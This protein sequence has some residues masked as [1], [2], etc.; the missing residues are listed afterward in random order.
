MEHPSI[1]FCIFLFGCVTSIEGFTIGV[2]QE[3]DNPFA[4]NLNS[5]SRILDSGR[6]GLQLLNQLSILT[7]ERSNQ[8]LRLKSTLISTLNIHFSNCKRV[9]PKNQKLKYSKYVR[10][11]IFFVICTHITLVSKGR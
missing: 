1:S 10:F 4:L 11:S 2:R 8:L 9:Q 6:I 7:M 5:Y 3:R